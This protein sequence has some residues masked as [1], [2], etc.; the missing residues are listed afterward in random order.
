MNT[1]HVWYNSKWHAK[2]KTTYNIQSLGLDPI[3]NLSGLQKKKGP[4]TNTF[5]YAQQNLIVSTQLLEFK[6]LWLYEGVI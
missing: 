2:N 6:I 5:E 3:H 4:N 1:I